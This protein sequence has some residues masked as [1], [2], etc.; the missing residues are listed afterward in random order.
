MLTTYK[1]AA[2]I[3]AA[4]SISACK[5]SKNAQ[6]ESER[7]NVVAPNDSTPLTMKHLAVDK[8]R[9]MPYVTCSE[10]TVDSL[11]AI[12]DTVYSQTDAY[13]LADL[14]MGTAD[15]NDDIQNDYNDTTTVVLA[16]FD[17]YARIVNSG[18]NEA[19]AAFVWHEVAKAQMKAFYEN[20]GSEWEE[21]KGY[22]A[23]FGVAN[24]MMGVY[25]SGN[26]RD[27]NIAAWRS[28]MPIDYRLIEAYKRLSDVC[29]N[30]EVVQL[31]HDDY[32]HTLKTFRDYCASF[33]TW[34]SDL[35]REQGETFQY[36]LDAKQ[37]YVQGLVAKYKKGYIGKRMV[38]K[39]LKEHRIHW[40][41]KDVKLTI[42]VLR[43]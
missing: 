29:G 19:D 27:M 41:N 9:I 39:C 20:I 30:A 42:H 10:Q 35:P 22:E 33:D 25:E 14:D 13:K 11:L 31:V 37:E 7:E 17:S 23:I 32:M 21:P 12:A 28:I 5:Q 38:L 6:S 26:Q 34:Y 18:T 8:Q 15:T 4:F 40:C 16:L 3:L 43:D 2:L 1:I 36:L 24:G